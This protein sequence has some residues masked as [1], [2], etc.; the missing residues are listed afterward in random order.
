MHFSLPSATFS[1][2]LK[3]A[4][5]AMSSKANLPVLGSILC[6]VTLDG[7]TL[8]IS[9]TDL[10][11]MLTQRIPLETP[12]GPG[13]ICLFHSSLSAIK[14][15]RNTP[16]RIDVTGT[17]SA[18]VQYVAG[19]MAARATLDTLAASEFPWPPAMPGPADHTCLLPTKTLLALAAS[20]PFQSEDE[21]RY[22]LNGA[23][24][25]PAD[26]GSI[27][28]TNGRFLARFPCKVL[29]APAI[30]PAKACKI[31]ARIG[32]G[33]AS[34]ARVDHPPTHNSYLSIRT[35]GWT[36]HTKLIQGNFPNYHQ[37]IP[38][39]GSHHLTFADP[40]GVAKWLESLPVSPTGNSVTLRPRFPHFVDLIHAHG[41]ITATAYLQGEPPE[42]A[43]NPHYMAAVLTAVPGTF[44]LTDGMNPA[45]IRTPTAHAVLMPMRITTEATEPAAA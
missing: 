26:G 8:E 30:L 40:A 4:R 36:L 17:H 34:A 19:G 29:P 12:G 43:F 14:P 32:P 31:I 27:I 25:D 6:R 37:V 45:L 1:D 16:V 9:A 28:A 42:I 38:E 18:E 5:L 15:D 24:L 22:V 39:G 23:F 3:R 21:T 33:A 20:L 2:A 10:D 35:P 41:R 44:T 13:E 11:L 7:R